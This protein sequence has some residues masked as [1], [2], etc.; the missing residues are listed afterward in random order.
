MNDFY[1][2]NIHFIL[3]SWNV[4]KTLLSTKKKRGKRK[5]KKKTKML[6]V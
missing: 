1:V 2:F 3:N 5:G 6:S 4:S